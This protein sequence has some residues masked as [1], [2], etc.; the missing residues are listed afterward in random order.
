MKPPKLQ[1]IE[2]PRDCDH[3]ENE[4]LEGSQEGSEDGDDY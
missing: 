1:P 4:P 3:F 2:C